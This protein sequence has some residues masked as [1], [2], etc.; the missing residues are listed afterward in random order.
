M[1]NDLQNIDFHSHILPRTDHGCKNSS[2]SI[3]QL[4]MM[5]E[6]QTD[7][8]V[9][10]PHFYPHIHNVLD[11]EA[12]V[13]RAIARLKQRDVEKAPL[14]CVGAEVLLCE[15]IDQLNGLD[16][17][18]IRGTDI[19]LLELPLEDFND[20]LFKTV[21]AVMENGYTVVLAHIDR[22]IKKEPEFIFS[23]LEEGALAQINPYALST[24]GP[25]KHIQ[26]LLSST[27]SIVAIGS[28]LHGSN[29]NALDDFSKLKKRLGDHYG[30]IMARSNELLKNAKK[31]DITKKD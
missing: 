8:V 21:E 6:A 27:E 13:D 11:F 3:L 28:D 4:S 5:R 10:T 7:I 31:I 16:K 22:Y 23:I 24:F 25:K 20:K 2:E 15:N 30:K 19:L 29:K 9:A 18:C 17:L 12:N 26:R 14:I 1:T